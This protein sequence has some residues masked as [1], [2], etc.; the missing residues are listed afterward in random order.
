MKLLFHTEQRSTGESPKV[1]S[2]QSPKPGKWG[3][4]AMAYTSV[5]FHQ[6]AYAGEKD[7]FSGSDKTA[8]AAPNG[9]IRA[10]LAWLKLGQL[11][12]QEAR[13]QRQ[14]LRVRKLAMARLQALSPHLLGDIGLADPGLT[15]E[16]DHGSD[17]LSMSNLPMRSSYISRF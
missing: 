9:S 5:E 2:T 14:K 13:A 15:T 7:T 1:T 6:D 8:A 12:S 3:V 11:K 10:M 4:T 16:A 17:R